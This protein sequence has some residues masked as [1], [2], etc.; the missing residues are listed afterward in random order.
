MKRTLCILLAL[1]GVTTSLWA[2]KGEVGERAPRIDGVEWISDAPEEIDGITMVLF[3][4]SANKEC[5]EHIESYNTLAYEF[6][7]DMNLIVLTREP[8]EQVASLLMHDYQFFY[9]ATDEQGHLFEDFGVR[10]VPYAVII[11]RKGRIEWAGN[12]Y[13]ID[14]NRLQNIIDL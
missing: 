10:H 6:R 13:Y 8:A 12:P 14:K 9:V 5:R 1:L 4:H 11:N 7:D 3:F 2:Q